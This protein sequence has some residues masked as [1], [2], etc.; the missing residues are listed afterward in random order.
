MRSA[1]VFAVGALVLGCACS[2][3][4]RDAIPV[5]RDVR[6]PDAARSA[7]Y[8]YVAKRARGTVGLVGAHNMTVDDARRIVDH[9][10]D[11]LDACARHLEEAGTLVDGAAT[12]VAATSR[13]GTGD[14]GDVQ[15]APGGPVAANALLCLI[16]PM[17]A[18][19]FP[20]HTGAGPLPALALEATWAPLGRSAAAPRDGAPEP[21]AGGTGQ[22]TDRP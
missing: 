4:T 2:P 19:T 9:V 7:P 3:G 21:D 6:D 16:A 8:A 20:S 11:E 17:R 18:T 10:A 1:R 22:E 13:G 14:V 15:L 12:L 5:T